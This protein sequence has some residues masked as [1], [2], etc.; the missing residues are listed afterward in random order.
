MDLCESYEVTTG[1]G[2]RHPWELAR[3]EVVCQLMAAYLGGKSPSTILDIGCGDAFVLGELSLR[4]PSTQ[5]VGIDTAFTGDLLTMLRR[6]L[7]GQ[8]VDLY[9]SLPAATTDCGQ[10]ADIVLLLDVIE[11][12][13]DDIAFL[14]QVRHSPLVGP[15]TKL[16][17]TTPAYQGLYGAHDVR[18]RHRRRYGYGV[19]LERLRRA[20]FRIERSGQFFL[21]PLGFRAAEIVGERWLRAK[22]D[23]QAGVAAWTGGPFLTRCVTTLLLL[24]FM[25]SNALLPVGIRLPGLSNYALCRISDL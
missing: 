22:K 13:Q 10:P 11:H 6:R 23:H 7:N 25:C 15:D 2:R 17:V 24:D 21:L 5:F 3:L 16:V 20:G 18:L 9:E 8:K 14:D 1:N 19:M 12:I 4:Y